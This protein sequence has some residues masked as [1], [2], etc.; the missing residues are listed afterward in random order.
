MG[1]SNG[2]KTDILSQVKIFSIAILILFVILISGAIKLSVKTNSQEIAE[3]KS[4]SAPAPFPEQ[5]PDSKNTVKKEAAVFKTYQNEKYGYEFKYPENWII[6]S[7][8]QADIFI[9][10]EPEKSGNFPIPHE[11]A[12]EIKVNIASSGA[13]LVKLARKSQEEGIDFEEEKI[14]IGGV[15][16]LK[17]NTRVCQAAGCRVFEWFAIKNDNFYHLSSIYPGITYDENFDQIISSLKFLEIAE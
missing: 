2:L 7:E 4:F 1:I 9:Q 5:L 6:Y 3:Q 16:G 11:G 8:N 10:P 15:D 14:E 12:L 13:D 17:I